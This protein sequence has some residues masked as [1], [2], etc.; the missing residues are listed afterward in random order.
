MT[1]PATPA[2]PAKP[3]LTSKEIRLRAAEIRAAASKDGNKQRA[4]DWM[5]MAKQ[6]DAWG[7][8]VARL[9]QLARAATTTREARLAQYR[10]QVLPIAFANVTDKTGWAALRAAG[11]LANTMAHAALAAE[12]STPPSETPVGT[13]TASAPAETIP[14]RP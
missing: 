11:S 7:A 9:E 1:D 6:L 3:K 4:A 10:C 12:T 13:S 2:A 8:G 14:T 5:D